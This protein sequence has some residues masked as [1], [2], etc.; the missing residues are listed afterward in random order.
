MGPGIARH[1]IERHSFH[2]MRDFAHRLKLKSLKEWREWSKSEQRPSNV[3]SNPHLTYKGKGWVSYPDW[4]GYQAKKVDGQMLPYASARAIVVKLNLT[5]LKEWQEWSKSGQRPSNVPSNPYLT[6]KGKG[7]VSW[8]DWMGYQY[9]KGDERRKEILPFDQARAVVRKL[10]MTSKQEW[11]GWSKSGQRPSNVPSHPDE[12]YKGKGWVSYPDWM[13]YQFTQGDQTRGIGKGALAFE[14]ARNIV[15]RLRLTSKKEWKEWSKS[16]QRPSNMPSNPDQLYKG[17]GWVSYPDWMGYKATKIGGQMLSYALARAIVVKLKLTSLKEWYE[18]CKSGQRPSNVPS[19]PNEVYK[20]KGWVSWP[21]W[22][23]YKPK[24]GHI[25]GQM[26]PFQSA[27][28]IVRRLRLTSHREWQEW[29]KSGQRP[30]NVPGNPAEAYKGK[31]WV[32]W[33][34]WMGYQYTNGDQHKGTSLM[35]SY[36]SARAIVV[37]LKLTSLKEWFEWSKSG[38]RPGNVPSAPHEVYKGKGWVSYPD[39]MGY[40]YTKGDKNK[41]RKRKRS[42]SQHTELEL[43]KPDTFS[44]TFALTDIL[45][46][47]SGQVEGQ[48]LSVDASTKTG[49]AIRKMLP[50]Q[51]DLWQEK[52]VEKKGGL[53]QRTLVHRGSI[54]CIDDDNK[55]TIVFKSAKSVDDLQDQL[56]KAAGPGHDSFGLISMPAAAT[57]TTSE[58]DAVGHTIAFAHLKDDASTFFLDGKLKS[59][60]ARTVNVAGFQKHLNGIY[61]KEPYMCQTSPFF[62]CICQG[63]GSETMSAMAQQ[64]SP[65]HAVCM[66]CSQGHSEGSNELMFCDGEGCPNAC[67]V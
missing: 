29:S 22:M 20:G 30:S 35:L 37:E 52:E 3:P 1:K 39:W 44:T 16:G 59:S 24:A 60:K 54:S 36:A 6:Y 38:Q 56:K 32:S 66:S 50:A 65:E 57:S 5:S 14:D 7:W 40:Q 15:R 19:A 33:P 61:A 51:E 47:Q 45:D 21:D 63:R 46:E 2:K 31:G 67:H 55:Y 26:L 9:T 58:Q 23:G 42:G 53:V 43:N 11:K 10:K 48:M 13:G 17:K 41:K 8:S 64:G 34:D 27:R 28:D 25:K 4:I 18:W 12:V 49:H 62:F